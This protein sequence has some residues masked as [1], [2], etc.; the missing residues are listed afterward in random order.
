MRTGNPFT[1]SFGKS[2]EE[3][4]SRIPQTDDTNCR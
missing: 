4:V 2:P 1:L 3:Y